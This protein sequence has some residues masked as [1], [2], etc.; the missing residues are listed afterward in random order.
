M[1]LCRQR[2]QVWFLGLWI[3]GMAA[4]VLFMSGCK[5]TS[6]AQMQRGILKG[7]ATPPMEPKQ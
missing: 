5:G 1:Y 6:D 2:L 7:S 4:S 3:I